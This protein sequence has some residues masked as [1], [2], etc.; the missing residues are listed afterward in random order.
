MGWLLP[1]N[2]L[3]WL[4]R[5]PGCQV[6]QPL[7]QGHMGGG[8]AGILTQGG[9]KPFP[10]E[11]ERL[12]PPSPVPG[13][14]EGEGLW[15]SR[16]HPGGQHRI[17]WVLDLITAFLPSPFLADKAPERL[18]RLG[19]Q[20]MGR[21]LVR[22]VWQV[23]R[24]LERQSSTPACPVSSGL[25]DSQPLAPDTACGRSQSPGGTWACWESRGWRGRGLS[26]RDPLPQNPGDRLK[27]TVGH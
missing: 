2:L 22:P 8:Q 9:C 23:G 3:T 15:Q 1:P 11:C 21:R 25:S 26:S 18:R 13:A 4:T 7:A 5:G 19:R 12:S 17:P 27:G 6:V 20:G 16:G 14:G 24:G 10:Q